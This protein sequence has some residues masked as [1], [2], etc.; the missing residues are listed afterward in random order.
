VPAGTAASLR[1]RG[2]DT[3]GGSFTDALQGVKLSAIAARIVAN[4]DNLTIERAGRDAEWR[5][6]IRPA[7]ASRS[8]PPQA[9]RGYP[10][11]RRPV[12][13]SWTAGSFPPSRG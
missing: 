2:S 7:A 13:S 11:P 6:P 1:L 5:R 4:G 8:I 12:R 3:L 9:S 10:H